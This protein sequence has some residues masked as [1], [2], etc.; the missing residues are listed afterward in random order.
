MGLV[1]TAMAGRR[2][3]NGYPSV[4]LNRHVEKFVSLIPGC[5][6]SGGYNGIELAKRRL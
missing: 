2:R 6:K 3:A 1:G 4:A 5:S